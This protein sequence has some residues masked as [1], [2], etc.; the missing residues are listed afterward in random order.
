MFLPREEESAL[1]RRVGRKEALVLVGPRRAGKSTLALR[2][3]ELWK[4]TRGA[5][6][7]LDLEKTGAPA[8]AG[9]LASALSKIP[10]KSLVVLDEIQA[11]EGWTRLVRD[12]IEY[13]RH[14]L[15][16]TGSSASLL[17][18]EIASS[19]AGRALP[20]SVLPL[21][22]RNARLWGLKSLSEYLDVG[23]YPECVLRPLDAR[24]LHAAYF[25]IA[26]L[27]DVAARKRLR[28][29]KPLRDLAVLVLSEPGKKISSSKT[30][31]RLGLSQPTFRSFLQALNDAFLVLSVPPFLRSPRETVVADAK[32]Y[33]YDTGLQKTVS[34]SRSEDYGRRVENLVAIELVRRGYALSHTD[35]CD[36]IALKTGAAPLAVQV[37]ASSD[38]TPEREI[39]G[40]AS[41]MRTARAEGMLL[42]SERTGL[43]MPSRAIEKTVEEWLLEPV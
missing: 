3:L 9:E 33:A 15:L 13:G 18:S 34:I 30:A 16:I 11:V 27:R 28:E 36:F 25:E 10:K 23:G 42:V 29:T 37:C 31:A 41:G 40:L 1:F 24:E 6:E 38:E 7:Y 2:L 4:A 14:R 35:E 22:Y 8:D 43:K 5:G 12:E 39:P 21:S 26:V 17:S 20:G 32:H 19:L